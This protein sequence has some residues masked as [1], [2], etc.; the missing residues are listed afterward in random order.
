MSKTYLFILGRHPT[1]SVAEL[2]RTVPALTILAVHDGVCIGTC[3]ELLP[4]FINTLGGTIKIA[5][6]VGRAGTMPEIPF[7]M[8]RLH[9]PRV[10]EG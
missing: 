3:S 4:G 9:L 1:L 8:L 7:E 5:E 2:T 10:P 6:V